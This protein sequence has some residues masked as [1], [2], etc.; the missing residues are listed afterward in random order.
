MWKSY[1]WKFVNWL[2]KWQTPTRRTTDK[3]FISV[4]A[5]NPVQIEIKPFWSPYNQVA[6]K[7]TA[8]EL[9]VCLSFYDE[10]GNKLKTRVLETRFELCPRPECLLLQKVWPSCITMATLIIGTYTQNLSITH[11]AFWNNSGIVRS[12]TTPL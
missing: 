12:M 8:Q 3:E 4:A 5:Q 10:K 11:P 2:Y 1:L 6:V 7:R 9:S